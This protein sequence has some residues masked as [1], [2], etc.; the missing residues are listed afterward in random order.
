MTFEE[1]NAKLNSRQDF[2]KKDGLG[3]V[4]ACLG[5]LGNPHLR[6]KSVH[7]TG[8]NGKGSVCAIFEAAA[9]AA[10]MRSAWATVI[11]MGFSQETYRSIPRRRW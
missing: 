2:A 4:Y 10:S 11:A 6:L 1:A 5:K 9:R 3:R 7:V 8:T